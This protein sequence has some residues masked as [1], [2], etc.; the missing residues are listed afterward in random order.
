MYDYGLLSSTL[1]VRFVIGSRYSSDIRP[2]LSWSCLTHHRIKIQRIK[3]LRLHDQASTSKLGSLGR[4]VQAVNRETT[5][6]L[7]KVCTQHNTTAVGLISTGDINEPTC[8]LVQ[9][10]CRPDTRSKHAHLWKHLILKGAHGLLLK[11]AR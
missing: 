2:P 1:S 7:C 5:Q 6:M 11:E 9:L 3:T 10:K 8:G 4:R